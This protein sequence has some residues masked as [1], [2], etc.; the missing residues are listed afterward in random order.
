MAIIPPGV[1]TM[2]ARFRVGG[3]IRMAKLRIDK[4]HPSLSADFKLGG[5]ITAKRIRRR[6]R[7]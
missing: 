6:R 2:A 3:G 7:T 1:P 4:T 5:G